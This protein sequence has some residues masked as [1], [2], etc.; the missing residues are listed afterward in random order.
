MKRCAK[1]KCRLKES[2]VLAKS[3]KGFTFCPAENHIGNDEAV[4]ESASPMVQFVS[5][6]DL[7]FDAPMD[8]E[9]DVPISAVLYDGMSRTKYMKTSGRSRCTKMFADDINSENKF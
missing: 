2:D 5:Y 3:E 4:I 1:H 8:F 7:V 6:L 9:N